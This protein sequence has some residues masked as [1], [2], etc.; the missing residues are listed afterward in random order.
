MFDCLIWF[1][2][3]NAVLVFASL[4]LEIDEGAI[5]GREREEYEKI[6]G[7]LISKYIIDVG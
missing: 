3:C 2:L 6:S 1:A 4:N 5:V 7:K